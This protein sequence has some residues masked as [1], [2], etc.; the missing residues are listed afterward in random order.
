MRAGPVQLNERIEALDI[1]RGFALFGIFLVNMPAFQW[2]VL[3]AELHFYSYEYT[4][5]DRWIRL[6]FDMFV[7]GKFFTI[8]SFLFGLGFYLFMQ[9]AEQK[10][11]RPR[12]LFARRLGALALFGAAHLVLLWYG[13]ILLTYALAGFALLLFYRCKPRTILIWIFIFFVLL[14]GI[15]LLNALSISL[16]ES[17]IVNLQADGEAKIQEAITV[18]REAGYAEWLAYRWT[19]EVVPMLLNLPFSALA[20]MFMFLMGLYAGKKKLFEQTSMNRRWIQRLWLICLLLSLPLLGM[21]AAI[22]F[23]L[24]FSGSAKEAAKQF[25]V[26]MSGPV[27]SLF[28][29]SSIALLLERARWRRLFKPFSYAGRMALTNYL[30]QSLIGVGLYAGLG[31]FGQMNLVLG[32]LIC[33]VVFPL[34]TVFSH[35]W[36]KKF[37]QGPM[38]W[39]WRT[40]TYGK[41]VPFK[42]GSTS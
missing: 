27:L 4:G 33:L 9:R 26:T 10:G 38:E 3:T 32:T 2:P 42:T 14:T 29:I 23:D 24:F 15:L 40:I 25:F 11:L 30:I 39:L 6:F 34:Q 5:I 16:M 1:I 7:E 37:R 19:E 31:W 8:F 36:L 13:D 22:H 17:Y 35:Y 41:A 20:V 28:Y 12:R 18:Y 21:V